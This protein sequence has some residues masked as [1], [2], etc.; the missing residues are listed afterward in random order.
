VWDLVIAALSV[1]GG[2]SLLR[3]HTC[4]RVIA[5]LWAGLVIVEGFPMLR[6]APRYGSVM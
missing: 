6:R 4:G 2:Y 3:G 1:S 5:Y